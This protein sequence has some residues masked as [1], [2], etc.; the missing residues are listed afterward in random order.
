MDPNQ[1]MQF[2]EGLGVSAGAPM[3]G[4]TA[5]LPITPKMTASSNHLPNQTYGK[6]KKNIKANPLDPTAPVMTGEAV[7]GMGTDPMVE[8]ILAMIMGQTLP[9]TPIMNETGEG[10]P[11]GANFSPMSIINSMMKELTE[12]DME[13]YADAPNPAQ[14][15]DG[16][17]Y[18]SMSGDNGKKP[19]KK[20]KRV[21][22]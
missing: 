13:A 7:P 11:H 6:V 22:D 8:S 15:I 4:N 2:L 16:E 1:L 14:K 21:T 17:K 12:A 10:M 20:K 5:A 19:R 3:F 18:K 9:G